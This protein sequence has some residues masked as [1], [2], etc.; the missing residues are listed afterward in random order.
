MHI[1]EVRPSQV[2]INCYIYLV[3]FI[4]RRSQQFCAHALSHLNLNNFCEWKSK[5]RW[6]AAP[7]RKPCKTLT[8]QRV[9]SVFC[10]LLNGSSYN[11]VKWTLVKFSRQKKQFTAEQNITFFYYDFL[12]LLP[13]D[14]VLQKKTQKLNLR[15]T[16]HVSRYGQ[17]E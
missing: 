7:K 11:A 8:L 13:S 6:Y 5:R 16:I 9:R 10:G 1:V 3:K 15:I 12:G 2:K 4:I 14:W 17:Y